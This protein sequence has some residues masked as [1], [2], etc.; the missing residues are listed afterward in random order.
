LRQFMS[1]GK[2]EFM[3]RSCPPTHSQWNTFS[4]QVV[5]TKLS[6][7]VTYYFSCILHYNLSYF[8]FTIV[9]A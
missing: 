4:T 1:L 7:Y 3:Y 2:L 5:I 6:Q 8:L 9:L